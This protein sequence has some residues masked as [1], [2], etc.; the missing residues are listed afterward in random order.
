[1]NIDIAE[2]A[3]RNLM[4][5]SDYFQTEGHKVHIYV[6]ATELFLKENPCMKPAVQKSPDPENPFEYCILN[7]SDN[8]IRNLHREGNRMVF[9]TRFNGVEYRMFVILGD[10]FGLGPAQGHLILDPCIIT[11][12]LISGRLSFRPYSSVELVLPIT[13]EE[14]A[15]AEVASPQEKRP[16]F[17]TV[18]K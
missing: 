6:Y 4:S 8:A 14:Q 10:I 13:G 15:A 3:M 12:S 17:L 9:D 1:M 7:I 18:V 5:Y 16:S 11:S 2:L